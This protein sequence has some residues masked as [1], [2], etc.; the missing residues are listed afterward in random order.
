MAEDQLTKNSMRSMIDEENGIGF[1]R[2]VNLNGYVFK[3]KGSWICFEL[4]NIEGSEDIKVCNIKYIHFKNN[5]D[6]KN[7]IA[8]CANFWMG[9]KVQFIYYK[10]KD[11]KNSALTFLQSLGFRVEPKTQVWKYN[12][13]CGT[14]EEGKNTYSCTCPVYNMYK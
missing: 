13:N 11:K 5:K 1:N 7:I 10:E 12:F 14:C 4:Q 6:L 9:N 2:N 8:N 3:F